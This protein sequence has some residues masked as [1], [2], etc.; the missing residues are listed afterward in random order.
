MK[1]KKNNLT[2]A[3]TIRVLYARIVCFPRL[4]DNFFPE[5]LRC[6]IETPD[7]FRSKSRD[8]IIELTR[9]NERLF[10]VFR[11]FL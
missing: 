6:F 2:A 8:K 9:Q 10:T 5:A 1:K 3:R 4:R 11:T 7:H